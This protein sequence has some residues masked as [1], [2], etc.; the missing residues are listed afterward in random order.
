MIDLEF[1]V[2]IDRPLPEVFAFLSDPLNLPRWQSS[3]RQVKA[4][5]EGD[6]GPGSSFA[7]TSEMLGRKIDGTMEI[8]A[9]ETG[10]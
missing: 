6:V 8:T 9:L 3:V 4:L 5:S 10:Q 2:L 7:L 1:G